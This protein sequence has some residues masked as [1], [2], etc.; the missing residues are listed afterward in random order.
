[1]NTKL[2]ILTGCIL[3]SVIAG[4][5]HGL[6]A[7]EQALQT[8]SATSSAGLLKVRDG[9]RIAFVGAGLGSRLI[10]FGEFET[11][12]QLRYPTGK[13]FIR[14]ICDEGN[15]PGFRPNPSRKSPWAFPGAEKFHSELAKGSGS[16]GHFETDDQWLKRLKTDTVIA[17]FGFN[18]A[19]EKGETG[20][21]IYKA[22]LDAFLKHTLA[23]KYNGK[24]APQVALVS[25]TAFEDLS[26]KYNTP[27]GVKENAVLAKYTAAMKEVAAKNG[28]VFVD[29]FAASKSWYDG[30]VEHTIDGAL[31]SSAGYKKLA[32]FLADSIFGQKAVNNGL[33]K[34]VQE[35]VM[36]KNYMWTNDYKVPNSVHV[37][38]RR[39]KPFGP[40]NYPDEIK[41]TREMTEV[42]DQLIWA[43]L[44]GKKFDLAAADAKTHKL[45][46]VA[47]NYK[48]SK[49]NG[50]IE[51][52]SGE[53][54]QMKLKLPAGYKMELFACEK[55]FPDL[56][57]P[58]QMSFDNKGRLWVATMPSYPHWKIG[59]PKPNDKLIILED[60]DGDGK[61]DKQTTYA[62]NL[63]IPIGFEIAPE[64]VYVSQSANL[65]LLKDT[66]KDGKADKREVLLSGFDDHDT[67]HAISA[68]CVDPSGAIMMGEGVFLH[69]NVETAYGPVR[70]TN[71]GF[72]RY[73][74]QRRK[75]ERYAQFKIPNPWGIAFDNY[76]QDF[77]L[78]TS[79]TGFSW[80]MPGSVKPRYGVNLGAPSIVKSHQVRPTS[81]VEFISSRHFPDD[82]QGDVLINNNIGFLGCKQHQMIEAG[83]GFTTKY[84]QD[85]FTSA[86]LN[87]RPVDL[88]FA[89]DGSLYVI[90]WSNVLIG[91]M[92]HNARDPHRDHVHGRVFRITY[93]SRPLVKPAKID[94]ASIDQLL[95]NLKLPEYRSRYRTRR[96]LRGRAAN[97]V[98]PKVKKWVA[99]LN[100]SD[101]KYEHQV[102]EALWVTWGLNATDEG[103]LRQ[104]LKAKDHKVRSAAARVLRFSTHLINDHVDLLVQ[105]AGDEHGRVRLEAITAASWLDKDNG[106]KVIAVAKA[107]GVDAYQKQ[108][109][110][111]GEAV[112]NG[113]EM[114]KAVVKVPVPRHLKKD[115][116]ASKLYKHGYEVFNHGENCASCHAKNGQGLAAANFPPL[117]G[118]KWMTQDPERVIK[119]ALKGIMG[120]MTVKGKKYNGAMPGFESRMNDN[121]LAAALTY[122]RNAWGNNGSVIKPADVAKVRKELKGN[123]NLMNAAE[124]LKKHPHT[125]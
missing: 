107:K 49:K 77:F 68:F 120:E 92:Q 22:E 111:A 11:E 17:F 124:L 2:S 41:K 65:V 10:H 112:L 6:Q 63:H 7:S 125:K 51:Y 89:P 25:P 99:G 59:D 86:D 85:L 82:V 88:E 20:L 19:F 98:L 42:R 76:G 90:D 93:P 52:L 47:T 109:V 21:D 123:P 31:F 43:T 15:T 5:E 122:A 53:E 38:G 46:P 72:M 96:E 105:A 91:H 50:T 27:V 71:G 18:S 70:G 78:H 61:A 28:V 121:D 80:M 3:G 97:D 104:L 84:R 13:L 57:N 94:G 4:S 58:V 12:L 74:P 34:N 103:I 119:I 67:H 69:S 64:G 100:K 32:P 26:K 14:N 16:N 37:Y 66:D 30:K 45:K 56:A 110:A 8:V 117:A 81:G 113:I 35:A 115:K 36:E 29:A 101:V 60:T 54:S 114:Q 95:E 9:E 87:F 33:R 1:M 23:Q 102:L 40:Q 75:L 55:E 73:N 24:S 39:Y 118:S 48:P 44:S 108:A 116:T 62:D 83:T 79:G 106:L